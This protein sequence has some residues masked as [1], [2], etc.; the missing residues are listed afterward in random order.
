MADGSIVINTKI[1]NS[2]VT[3]DTRKMAESFKK[4]STTVTNILSGSSKSVQN[5]RQKIVETNIAIEEVQRQMR[6]IVESAADSDAVTSKAFEN[7]KLK[8]EQIRIAMGNLESQM[9]AIAKR[10]EE[11]LSEFYKDPEAL[12]MAVAK[13]LESD[14]AYQKLGARFDSLLV[15]FQQYKAAEEQA[16]RAA[17][18]SSG[19]K[20]REYQTLEKRLGNLQ[21]RLKQYNSRLINAQAAANK[22]NASAGLLSRGF[23]MLSGRISKLVTSIFVFNVLRKGITLIRDYLSAALKTNNELNQ[24]YARVKGNLLIAFQPIYE[25]IQPRLVEFMKWLQKV[26]AQIAVFTS[27]LAGKTVK[28]SAQAA[29]NLNE[30]AKA[31]QAV[32]KTAKE[33]TG[34]L[35]GFDEINQLGSQGLATGVDMPGADFTGYQVSE[36]SLMSIQ[37]FADKIRDIWN[38][39][40]EN[41]PLVNGALGLFGLALLSVFGPNIV[42]KI[43]GFKFL[44]ESVGDAIRLVQEIMADGEFTW[45]RF[46]EL[47]GIAGKAVLGLGLILGMP[48]VAGF[49]L[50]LWGVSELLKGFTDLL[51]GNGDAWENLKR[52]MMG[53]GKIVIGAF[54]LFGFSVGIAALAVGAF[55]IAAAAIASVWDKLNTGEKILAGIALAALGAAAAIAIFHTSWSL[56]TAAAAIGLA[57]AGLAITFGLVKGKM[58]LG[59]GGVDLSLPSGSGY[60]LAAARSF[61]SQNFS[62]NPL[63]H[64][65]TGAVIPANREFLAV[66]GDQRYGKNIET[67]ERLLREIFRDE[68][69]QHAG[70]D[71][72]L[73]ARI[74]LEDGPVVGRVQRRFTRTGRLI[75]IR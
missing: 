36:E 18:A 22:A 51:S 43:I 5:I 10:T 16:H 25:V 28:Q 69:S 11:D 31:L 50:I 62:V 8:V 52:I 75:S 34:S 20:S 53:T 6:R 49:G 71:I 30:Q 73:N 15:K 12:D 41:Q 40:V 42:T 68:L 7:A 23:T 4:F 1:D 33:A 45:E 14:A 61:G 64:L 56:G 72:T 32:S 26:T 38:W 21:L 17:I 13:A 35:A 44:F 2:G 60:S 58:G 39:I 54:M 24:S 19:T 3:G 67:P 74:E 9:D 48:K 29:K 66:L 59:S 47:V 57:L 65:A 46:T 63:P 70:G 27:A 55:V 37:N